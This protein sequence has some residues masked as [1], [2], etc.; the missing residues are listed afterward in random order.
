LKMS[1]L[2]ETFNSLGFENV[3]TYVQ[4]GNVVFSTDLADEYSLTKRVE[5]VLKSRLGLDVVVIIR[6]SNELAR[7]VGRNPF[8]GKEQSK[9]HVTFSLHKA[10]T[11]SNREDGRRSGRR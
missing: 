1:E 8:A 3:R 10:C 11:C 6:T 5:K 4:S 7:I 9:L 2:A